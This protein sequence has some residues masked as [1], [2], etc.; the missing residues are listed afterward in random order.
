MKKEHLQTEQ[1]QKMI[2]TVHLSGGGEVCIPEGE[3][4]IGSLRL[5]SNIT[6]HL[7]AG[8]KIYGS[9][10]Y[11]DYTD[12]HV[13]TTLGYVT[14]PEYKEKWNLPD[15][16]IYGMFCAFGEE[17]ISIVGEEGTMIDGQDCYDENGEEKFRGPM[18]IIFSGCRHI[19]LKG[20]TFVNSANWSHQLDSCEDVSI[21][22]VTVLAGHDG[23]NL[24]HCTDVKIERCTMKTGDDCLAGYDVEHLRVTDCDLN[25]ACNAVRIGGRDLLLENC[26][27][28]GP[29]QYPHRSEQTFEAHALFK[30][31]A[32]GPDQIRNDGEQ[33]CFQNCE[34]YKMTKLFVYQHG[35]VHWMQENRPIRSLEIL[36]VRIDGLSQTSCMKGCGERCILTISDVTLGSD[37]CCPGQIILQTDESVELVLRHVK[38]S[39]PVKIKAADESRISM[40]DCENI[41]II[42]GEV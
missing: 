33:I 28:E 9:R 36:H 5:Y 1:L 31:Y 26:R 16:Y 41:E 4:H 21:E 3:Y 2:D 23:F 18:G 14:D 20:Y 27:M 34:I 38:S 37:I 7:L 6:L 30:Y 22:N 32:I 40:E 24:H 29:G 13:P 42:R 39:V 17:N 15:Y 11:R 10:D 8:A 12:F 35:C 25:T 19:T